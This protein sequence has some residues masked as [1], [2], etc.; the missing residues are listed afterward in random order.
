MFELLVFT[1]LADGRSL[2]SIILAFPFSVFGDLYSELHDHFLKFHPG[3]LVGKRKWGQ[4][5]S[6]GMRK[7]YGIHS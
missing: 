3:G 6:P 7:G 2:K 4:Q 5:E 1:V